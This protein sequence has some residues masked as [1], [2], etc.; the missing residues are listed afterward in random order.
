MSSLV[1]NKKEAHHYY[2][3]TVEYWHGLYT[4]DEGV[5][6]EYIASTQEAILEYFSRQMMENRKRMAREALH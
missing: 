4:N 5:E 3:G 2:G 1:I 6:E